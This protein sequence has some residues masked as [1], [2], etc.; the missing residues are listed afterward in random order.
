VPG[1]FSQIVEPCARLAALGDRAGAHVTV[2]SPAGMPVAF[3]T[4]FHKW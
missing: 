4:R 2:H 1:M 3:A